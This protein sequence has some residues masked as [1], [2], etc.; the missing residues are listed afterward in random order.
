MHLLNNET[1]LI[2]TPTKKDTLLQWGA[3]CKSVLF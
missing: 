1:H 3:S 2:R